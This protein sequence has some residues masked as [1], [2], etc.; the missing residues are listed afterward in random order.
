MTSFGCLL[1]SVWFF[2]PAERT[3]CIIQKASLNFNQVPSTFNRVGKDT[4]K[5]RPMGCRNVERRWTFW[6]LEKGM[7]SLPGLRRNGEKKHMWRV[8]MVRVPWRT[9][10]R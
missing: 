9:Q 7:T 5:E 3:S 8:V 6:M 4:S 1:R 10:P 2:N